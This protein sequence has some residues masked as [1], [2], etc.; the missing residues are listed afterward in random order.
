MLTQIRSICTV[1]I[2][3]QA[4]VPGLYFKIH[5]A[6]AFTFQL[7]ILKKCKYLIWGWLML[8]PT[9]WYLGKSQ[10][11]EKKNHSQNYLF[12]YHLMNLC[13]YIYDVHMKFSQ[14]VNLKKA[15]VYAV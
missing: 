4:Q 6:K 1:V 3:R 13:M 12:E 11:N 14:D 5:L 7:S 8:L 9:I 2:G 10:Q 15:A